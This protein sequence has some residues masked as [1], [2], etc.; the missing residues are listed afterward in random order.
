MVL[1]FCFSGHYTLIFFSEAF[2]ALCVSQFGKASIKLLL[3][4]ALFSY[5]LLRI[6]RVVTKVNQFMKHVL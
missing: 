5:F 3:V 2:V 6:I 1:F 4:V